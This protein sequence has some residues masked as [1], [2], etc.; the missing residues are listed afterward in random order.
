MS[1]FKSIWILN[2]IFL[3][4]PAISMAGL[5]SGRSVGMGGAYSAVASGVEAAF[6]NPANLGFSISPE[7]NLMLFSL[8]LNV[9]NNSFNLKQYNQYN[10]TF[11]TAEDK[12][13]ILNLIPD[14]GF[15]G[16]CSIDLMALGASWH[17][18]AFTI[19]GRGT[20]ALLLP[21]D[22]LQAL[23]F[24]NAI[25]DTILVS[26]MD[27][28]ASAS[29]DFGLSYGRS[30]WK[31]NHK[32]LCAGTTIRIIR[33]LIYQKIVQ[34]QGEVVTLETGVN[35]AGNFLVQS[36]EGGTGF[37]MDLGLAL[38]QTDNWSFGISL[39]NL[40]SRIKWDKK[41]EIREYQVRIDSLMAENF[42]EDSLVVEHSYTR[43]IN[44]FVRHLPI[45][46]Q[47]GMAY[48]LRQILVTFDIRHGLTRGTGESTKLSASFGAE[49]RLSRWF[50]LRGGFSVVKNEG[51]TLTQGLGMNLGVY[52]LDFGIANLNGVWPTKSQGVCIAISNHIHF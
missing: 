26:G 24:G 5:N 44:S 30:V 38:K 51:I 4:I 29:V 11:L 17:N 46:A 14:R 47:M 27:V 9:N 12:Q 37:G 10:G 16:S 33:G 6:W 19:S 22:P 52:S 15:M 21:K 23:F 45:M 35:G 31:K 8:G 40:W 7:M 48:Q 18:F 42:D 2:I 41:T 50:Q 36:A 32:E 28:E 49:Y 20:S 34:A 43:K 39:T 1:R 3:L 13:T 25:N